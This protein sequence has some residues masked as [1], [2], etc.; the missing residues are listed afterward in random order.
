VW[1][2]RRRKWSPRAPEKG[3]P[4]VSGPDGLKPGVEN[5]GVSRRLGEDE[6]SGQTD[7]T[8]VEGARRV[9]S[10]SGASASGRATGLG[11]AEMAGLGVADG[12]TGNGVWRKP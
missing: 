6:S 3:D 2:V 5:A 11:A 10:N 8:L 4:G 9:K 12:I 7:G 1:G